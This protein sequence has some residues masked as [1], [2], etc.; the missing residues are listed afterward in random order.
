[1]GDGGETG[2]LEDA[3]FVSACNCSRNF[4]FS[5]SKEE[6]RFVRDFVDDIWKDR[7]YSVR[8]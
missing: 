8:N 7:P 5:S 1:M 4:L 3:A 6:R 2:I